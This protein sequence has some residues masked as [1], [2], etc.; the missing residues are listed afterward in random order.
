MPTEKTPAS[1]SGRYG[2]LAWVGFWSAWP[3]VLYARAAWRKPG[4]ADAVH[5]VEAAIRKA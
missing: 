4:L 1:L 2:F 3:Y 5:V